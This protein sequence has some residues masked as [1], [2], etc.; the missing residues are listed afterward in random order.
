MGTFFYGIKTFMKRAKVFQSLATI[1]VILILFCGCIYLIQD[2]MIY[3]PRSYDNTVSGLFHP[4]LLEIKYT[5]SEGKQTVFYI[6]PSKKTGK[7]STIWLL[8]GGNASLA[9]FW[10]DFVD[11]YPG[12]KDTGFLLIDYPGYGKCEGNP[13]PDTILES[14]S[15]ALEELLKKIKLERHDLKISLLGHSLGAAAALLLAAK[16]NINQIILISP[17]TSMRDMAKRVVGPLHFLLRDNYDNIAHLEALIKSEKSVNITIFH[18]SRDEVIPVEMSRI[19]AKKFS[20]KIKYY[21]IKG[22]N[23]NSIINHIQDKIYDVMLMK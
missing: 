12:N 9:L 6:P 13:S 20:Q 10:R 1:L 18:G 8:F 22:A 15:K 17:F 21:E 3:F 11:Y 2:K 5:T 14:T 7:V 16:N 23:H 19:L 4:P